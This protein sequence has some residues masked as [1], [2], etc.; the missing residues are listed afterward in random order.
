[1]AE[2]KPRPA[3]DS[4]SLHRKEWRASK[5]V[6]KLSRAG[7][8][9][10]RAMASS[11]G[12]IPSVTDTLTERTMEAERDAYKEEC[13]WGVGAEPQFTGS[14]NAVPIAESHDTGE[15]S[16]LSSGQMSSHCQT[17]AIVLT[18]H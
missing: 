8:N 18:P 11:V 2:T 13:R 4:L 15:T 17:C 5:E 6:K 10:S 1:M 14:Y 3:D 7:R 12:F 16:V 9:S